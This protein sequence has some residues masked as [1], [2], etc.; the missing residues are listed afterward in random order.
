MIFVF[1]FSGFGCK[2]SRMICSV[3][4]S[5]DADLNFMTK[6][7]IKYSPVILEERLFSSQNLHLWLHVVY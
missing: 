5:Q 2:L 7:D 4:L 6:E 3:F 1:L